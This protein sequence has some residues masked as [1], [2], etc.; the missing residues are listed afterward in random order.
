M[1]PIPGSYTLPYLYKS[2]NPGAKTE[3]S[4]VDTAEHGM[5]TLMPWADADWLGSVDG[6]TTATRRG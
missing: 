6:K 2:D 4:R 3:F 5:K 1:V